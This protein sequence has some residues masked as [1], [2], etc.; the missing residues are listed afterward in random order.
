MS[1]CR[2]S[3]SQLGARASAFAGAEE[4]DIINGGDSDATPRT[5]IDFSC[6]QDRL[7]VRLQ[8]YLV[9]STTW[10]YFAQS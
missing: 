5:R 6:N 10:K 3:R 4:I 1:F 2:F 9:D 8:V 7:V